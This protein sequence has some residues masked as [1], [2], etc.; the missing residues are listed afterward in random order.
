[1]NNKFTINTQTFAS[2][3]DK[4]QTIRHDAILSIFQDIATAHSIE[5]NV[6]YNTLK[7]KSNAFWVITKLKFKKVGQI[8]HNEPVTLE[9]WPLKPDLIRFLRDFHI[10]AQN[11]E[12]HGSSEWC[13]L[14][15]N[16]QS[17]RRSNTVCYPVD[18]VH[19]QKRADVTPFSKLNEQTTDS[20]FVYTYKAR[21]NDIDMNEHVNNLSYA[22][23]ALNAF[24]LEE[25]Y[26]LSLNAFEIHFIS[27]CY[28]GDEICIY[29]KIVDDK[30]YIDGKVNGKQVFKCLFYNE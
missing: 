7:E 8:F 23:M 10:S 5:M 20:D 9:T 2:Q 26:S 27:Q 25:F 19:E 3:C 15:C 24:S 30:I 21:L 1:M 29:K 22:K 13:M 14:D 17:I 6:D 11:G 12:I 16:T 18:L 28:F 4:N